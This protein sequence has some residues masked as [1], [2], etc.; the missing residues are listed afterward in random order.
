VSSLTLGGGG[1]GGIW[2]PTDRREAVATVRTAVDAGITLLDTAPSYGDGE[3]E[4]VIGEAFDGRL[5]AGVRVTS[6]CLLGNRPVDEVAERL[7]R[8]VHESL[9]RLRVDHLDLFFLHSNLVPDDYRY[10]DDDGSPLGRAGRTLTDRLGTPWDLWIQAVRPTLEEM[11]RDGLIGA[12][13]LTGVGLPRTLLGA[14]RHEHPPAAIQITSNL[15]DSPGSMRRY[16][17]PA[18]PRDLILAAREAGVGVLG[19]RAVQAGALCREI[20]R[21]LPADHPER[22]DHERAAPF[23]ALADELGFDPADLAHRYALAMPGVDSVILG[24]KN[25]TELAAAVLGAEAPPLD[26]GIIERID[27]LGLRD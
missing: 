7:Y 27:D 4:S 8:S 6:K 13:G 23:R 15:L 22:I 16:A 21:E 18:R 3:A 25:R 1:I 14:L 17:E 24:V 11:V 26:A 10:P 19:I 9:A 12:W 5:P 2:G 20:D